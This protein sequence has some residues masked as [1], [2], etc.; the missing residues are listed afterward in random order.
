MKS[1]KRKLFKLLIFDCDGVLFDSSKANH[2]YYNEICIRAGRQPMTDNEFKYVHMHTA[3]ESIR[4]LFSDYPQI[5]NHAISIAKTLSYDD[6]VNYIEFEA[7][8]PEVLDTIKNLGF[9]M[10]IST[11]RSTTIP[12]LVKRFRLYKWFDKIVSALDVEKPKPDPEGVEKILRYFSLESRD[13]IYIGDSKVDEEV[14]KNAS[15]PLIA[16][17]NNTLDALFHVK[18]FNEIFDIIMS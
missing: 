18:H 3:N 13:A 5:I 15:I 4:F 8:V 11:N 2:K 16:Y 14:S 17:K 12:L 6:F 9:Y 1:Y 10:A 7:G